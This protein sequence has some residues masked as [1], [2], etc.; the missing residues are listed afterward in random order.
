MPLDV[1]GV[2]GRLSDERQ[3]AAGGRLD[4]DR[5]AAVRA[6]RLRGDALGLE[7]ERGVDVASVNRAAEQA[8]ADLS[9]RA[10]EALI[11]ARQ[12]IVG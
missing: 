3:Y 11:G 4:G 6:K 12:V 5:G 7:I 2:V 8:I 1:V 9:D 10:G